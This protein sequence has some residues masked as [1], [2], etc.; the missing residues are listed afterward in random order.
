M[1]R[2]HGSEGR[3][4]RRRMV[5]VCGLLS[6]AC[7]LV[8]ASGYGVMVRDGSHWRDLAE[9]QRHRR[10]RLVPKRGSIYDR[11]GSSLAVSI[12]V[13]SVSLD[14]RELLRGVARGEVP[15]VA[16]RAAGRI[17]EA[18][19]LDPAKVEKKI[20]RGRRFTWLKRRI[21]LEEAERLRALQRPGPSAER[22][23]GLR[24][25]AEGKRYYPQRALA[26][27]LLGFVAPDG[28]GKDGLE[29][30]LD[31]ELGGHRELL[32][33]LRDRS[34]R[35][36]FMDGIQDERTLAGHDIYLS[37]DQGIQNLAERE[38]STA[39]RTFEASS[40]SVVVLEPHTGEILALANFPGYNPND[41]RF[42]HAENRR[43][44]AVTDRFEPGSTV[45]IFTLA[46]GLEAGAIQ[47]TERLFCENGRMRVD[48]VVIPDTHPAEWLS[49]PQVLAIS[50]N[51]CAA[52]VGLKIGGR[53][54]YEAL[55][56]FGFGQET[57]VPLPGEASGVLRP[58]GRP[59]VAVE[60]ASAAF[61]QGISVTNLQLALA[62]A[63]IANGG[64]LLDPIL[65]RRVQGA[66]GELVREAAPR[67]RRQVVSPAVART[68]AEMMIAV[69]EGRGTGVKAA[70]DGF[71]VAGKT[72]TA[73]KTDPRTGRY[74]LDHYVASF[75]GFVPARKP[76][77]VIAVTMDEPALE[78][79]GGAVA[80]P[81]FRRIAESALNYLGVVP[82]GRR[83]ADVSKLRRAPD[84]ARAAYDV[85]RRARGQG[86]PVQ[87]VKATGKLLPGQIRVP[88]LTGFPIREAVRKGV[89]LGLEPRVSGTGLLARQVPAPGGVL[90]KGET[91]VM[92]FEP[93]T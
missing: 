46:A 66:G 30:S 17:G 84:P 90:T 28:Q 26:G 64:R 57:A 83:L 27:S 62:T 24:V 29:L 40:G 22:L 45:K 34:G 7:G 55:R 3:W 2:L 53:R 69:T 82:S 47:P 88:D 6:L 48:D 81:V 19:G 59:W 32:T 11:N 68:V 60:T 10:L 1:N 52:K 39:A 63:A 92:V 16:R 15:L 76:A 33:G 78:H 75:V 67:V 8:V 56:R 74:S 13:P 72:A 37:I 89:E 54:L 44:R 87:E 51:I 12:D 4:V 58:R 61:G 93:A 42:S 86:P 14:A 70:I 50:S 73:Q 91:L 21:T 35:L 23:R 18:L 9:K 71:N 80:A 43:M 65:V 31:A 79:S 85:M 38:L 49:L 25:E 20:L 41:Y 36:L 77:L 5:A